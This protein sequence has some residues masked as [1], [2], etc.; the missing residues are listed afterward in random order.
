M[1]PTRA[2]MCAAAATA[3]ASTSGA[4]ARRVVREISAEYRNVYPYRKEIS[5]R[6]GW[7]NSTQKLQWFWFG[8]KKYGVLA[9][10]ANNL[11]MREA[12]WESGEKRLI[13]MDAL[14][15]RYWET[16][17][18]GRKLYRGYRWIDYPHHFTNADWAKIPFLWYNWAKQSTGRSPPQMA[19]MHKELGP[20]W[21]DFGQLNYQ[22]FYMAE[23]ETSRSPGGAEGQN[24]GSDHTNPFDPD[25]KKVRRFYGHNSRTRRYDIISWKKTKNLYDVDEFDPEDGAIGKLE[26]DGLSGA[27]HDSWYSIRT[28]DKNGDVKKKL[29]NPMANNEYMR[30]GKH[31]GGKKLSEIWWDYRKTEADKTRRSRQ[32]VSA[33]DLPSFS[34]VNEGNTL[35]GHRNRANDAEAR[36]VDRSVAWKKHETNL[37]NEEFQGAFRWNAS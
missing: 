4:T 1:Q 34:S 22:P 17:E 27:V 20:A 5:Y 9:N 28:Y 25:F 29:E 10:L 35:Y 19:A 6:G 11:R 37:K 16:D 18:M 13:G 26:Y 7:Q 2:K 8:F 21:R 3:S 23:H 14:G 31:D 12:W 24:H 32:N 30:F 33:F 15:H 36:S